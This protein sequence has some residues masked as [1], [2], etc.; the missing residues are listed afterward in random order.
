[1]VPDSMELTP[2]SIPYTIILQ[3]KFPPLV[4]PGE[5]MYCTA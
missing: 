2:R 5:R 4:L 1:M 3:V